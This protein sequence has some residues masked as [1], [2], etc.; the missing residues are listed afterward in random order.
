MNGSA[1]TKDRVVTI[2]GTK[3]DGLPWRLSE[4]DAIS[5]IENGSWALHVAGS[6]NELVPLTVASSGGKKYLTARKLEHGPDLL[7]DLP[8][9]SAVQMPR[10]DAMAGSVPGVG[11]R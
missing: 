7:R 9:C 1:S 2:G 8:E 11:D 4:S 10:P 6:N 3:S 5:G